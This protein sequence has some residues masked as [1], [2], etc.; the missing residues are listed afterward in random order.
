MLAGNSAEATCLSLQGVSTAAYGV[1][2]WF[3]VYGWRE[4]ISAPLLLSTSH[5]TL[6]LLAHFLASR[7]GE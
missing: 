4:E 6:A 1:C 5:L 3:S 7:M 2:A